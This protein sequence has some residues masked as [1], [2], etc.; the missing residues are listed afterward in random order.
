MEFNYLSDAEITEGSVIILE[1][2]A[3]LQAYAQI[4]AV[5]IQKDLR[6]ILALPLDPGTASNYATLVAAWKS[7]IP[8]SI[9]TQ[10][11]AVAVSEELYGRWKAGAFCS[12]GDGVPGSTVPWAEFADLCDPVTR[13]PIAD[14]NHQPLVTGVQRIRDFLSNVA[15]PAMHEH[16]GQYGKSITMIEGY[17][18]ND[19]NH[20]LGKAYY[21]PVP[22]STTFLTIDK[23]IYSWMTFDQA[24][25]PFLKHA[26]DT[27]SHPILL[28]GHAFYY[29]PPFAD[30]PTPAHAWPRGDGAGGFEAHHQYCNAQH[31]PP[32]TFSYN[33]CRYA[34]W[35]AVE[36]RFIGLV[37]FG[38]GMP[39]GLKSVA[40]YDM[41]SQRTL[42]V[43]LNALLRNY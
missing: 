18:N 6:I 38:Y 16:F 12:G 43:A 24:V 8:Q 15:H 3:D 11:R 2:N 34:Y 33:M 39:G 27:L 37:W 13:K 25:V 35:A 42:A 32:H 40:P 10:L 29:D 4:G 21:N 5:A 41:T 19:I 23:Y 36:P 14:P 20:P 28:V 7:Q 9:W 30:F 26:L 22:A 31:P 17:F 1:H